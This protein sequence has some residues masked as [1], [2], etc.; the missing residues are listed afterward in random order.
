M[1][2]PQGRALPASCAGATLGRMPKPDKSVLM[3]MCLRRKHP[4]A[5]LPGRR[6]VEY[7]GRRGL[8]QGQRNAE[9]ARQMP[10]KAH[11]EETKKEELPTSVKPMCMDSRAIHAKAPLKGGAS[12]QSVKTTMRRKTG[13]VRRFKN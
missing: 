2:P 8:P 6:S 7:W 10:A 13:S 9:H 5:L 1:S 12:A 3:M 11:S 4:L